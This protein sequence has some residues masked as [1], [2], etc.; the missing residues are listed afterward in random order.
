[1]QIF[2]FSFEDST[3]SWRCNKCAL[4]D[5]AENVKLL[6]KTLQDEIDSTHSIESMEDLLGKYKSSLHPNHFLVISIKN[7][8]ID[9]YG[10][11]KGHLLSELPDALLRR[12]IELCEE[13]LEILS[14]FEAGKSR[15]RALMMYD[16]HAPTVLHAK[17]QYEQNNLT[18]TEYLWQLAKARDLLDEC[19]EILSW[20][21]ENSCKTF[22]MAKVSLQRLEKL[23]DEEKNG[24]KDVGS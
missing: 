24:W 20:E 19:S 1:M 16:L 21:D 2:I 7:A 11:V 12:K 4:N 3:A 23:I 5:D 18:S 6:L 10:H 22:N 8:L 15:T 9:S 13:V 14:V 17:S